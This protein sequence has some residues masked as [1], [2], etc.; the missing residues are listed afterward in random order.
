MKALNLKSGAVLTIFFI[1]ALSLV[2]NAQGD[3]S[4]GNSE[5]KFRSTFNGSVLYSQYGS[6]SQLQRESNFE[7]YKPANAFDSDITTAWV[8]G[9]DGDGS[10]EILAAFTL[11]YSSKIGIL[12]GYGT[13]KHFKLNNRIKSAK[14]SVF[15]IAGRDANQCLG[16][17]Y[18]RGKLLE[19][20][21]LTFED[22]MT[23]QYFSLSQDERPETGYLYTIEIISV[24]KG[25]KYNDT[26][27]AE[28][29]LE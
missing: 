10:G 24:Y 18:T 8:E 17:F 1:T 11:I 14:L 16:M 27:I 5:N 28:V 25:S 13:L 21:M 4:C 9:K 23:I 6:T 7:K 2:L 26:C 22:T 29:V 15:E 20:K 12:P 3:D 19:T